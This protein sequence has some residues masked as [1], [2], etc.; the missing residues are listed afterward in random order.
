MEELSPGP[1]HHW[2]AVYAASSPTAVSWY[3]AVPLVSVELIE[4]LDVPHDAAILDLGGGAS[5]LV[6]ALL[7]RNYGDV[8]VLDIS[9]SALSVA[10]TRL[11]DDRRVEW[12]EVDLFD[13]KPKRQYD[14]WHDRAVLHFLVDPH[15]RD[16][17]L[18]LMNR[19]LSPTGAVIIGTFAN[20]GPEQCS[21]L[22]VSRYA[23]QELLELLGRDF[24]A[25]ATRR[26]LHKTPTGGAQ[27]FSWVAA[28][29]N[30]SPA[31]CR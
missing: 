1:R 24:S 28:S 3:Q 19:A 21:G 16:R 5:T 25:V 18:Q 20:D 17:Y 6:D 10:R 13:W 30:R 27:P 23:P 26:E 2:E 15:L 29:K 14:L 9:R 8:S 22:P 7:A 11:G 31:N 4:R 12:I